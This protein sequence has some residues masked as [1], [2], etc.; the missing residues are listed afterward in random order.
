M[1]YSKK[2]ERL[3]ALTE[4]W[5]SGLL[6]EC[7]RQQLTGDDVRTVLGAT[8]RAMANIAAIYAPRDPQ[9][10]FEWAGLPEDAAGHAICISCAPALA[11]GD[12]VRAE[13]HS[14]GPN[15][16]ELREGTVVDVVVGRYIAKGVTEVDL[17]PALRGMQGAVGQPG[18]G[19]QC[20]DGRRLDRVPR[21]GLAMTAAEKAKR[22][23]V[24]PIVALELALVIAIGSVRVVAAFT[25]GLVRHG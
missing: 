12:V 5:I 4:E 15:R 19:C 2:D 7:S 25:K 10:V 22:L 3:Q 8:G 6:C 17:P 1:S 18:A 23:I 14:S 9:A 11:I 13:I 21:G 20:Q 16:T 24:V